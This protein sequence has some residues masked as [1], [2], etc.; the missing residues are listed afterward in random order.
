M[1]FA[2][3]L[4]RLDGDSSLVIASFLGRVLINQFC[5]RGSLN[6]RFAPQATE[7]PRC[8]ELTR[9]ANHR[10]MRRNKEPVIRSPRPFAGMAPGW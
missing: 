9:C 5:T 3:L 4:N 7:L 2:A 8:R 6:F 1:K 10:L